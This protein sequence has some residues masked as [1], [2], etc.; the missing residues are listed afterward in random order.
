MC[1][2]IYAVEEHDG[3]KVIHYDG[4]LWAGEKE[5]NHDGIMCTW[6]REY[7]KWC[8]LGGD[9][10]D[11]IAYVDSIEGSKAEF[12]LYLFETV[13]Q[14]GGLITDDE[15]DDEIAWLKEGGTELHMDDVTPETPCGLYW[16]ESLEEEM[17]K[18]ING[19]TVTATEFFFDGCHKFYIPESPEDYEEM[20]A[21]GWEPADLYPIRMLPEIWVGSCP[22][23]F[24][25]SV[26]F[27]KTY[28]PQCTSARFEGWA[29]DKGMRYELRYLEAEQMLA[30]GEIDEDEFAGMVS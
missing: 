3:R 9:L 28:V 15:Y 26:D 18:K 8:G 13:Q 6:R 29:L 10:H 30:N 14:Y 2:E 25:E 19:I 4:F 5:P 27:S 7:G 11:T 22:L 1:I 12:I 24:I 16:Y 20:Y 23:R 17:G 21:R